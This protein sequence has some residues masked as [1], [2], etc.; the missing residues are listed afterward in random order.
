LVGQYDTAVA[1]P[2]CRHR[3]MAGLVPATH[4]FV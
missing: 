4:D 2:L 3:V 1:S